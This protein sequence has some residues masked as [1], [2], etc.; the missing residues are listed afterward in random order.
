MLL[1]NIKRTSK[2]VLHKKAVLLSSTPTS[3]P[4][5][6]KSFVYAFHIKK[7]IAIMKSP[8]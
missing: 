4:Q 6:L 1:K 7:F 5:W 2:E 8:H 3:V